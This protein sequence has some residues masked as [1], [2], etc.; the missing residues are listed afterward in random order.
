MKGVVH[1]E[2]T[3]TSR[4]W[5][6]R[7][8]ETTQLAMVQATY[9]TAIPTKMPATALGDSSM[10]TVCVCLPTGEMRTVLSQPVSAHVPPSGYVT[11][12]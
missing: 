5:P 2:I 6:V 3:S 7:P 10:V 9:N 8:L 4:Y 11:Q 1:R 12:P